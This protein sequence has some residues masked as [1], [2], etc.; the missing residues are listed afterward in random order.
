MI[1]ARIDYLTVS[2]ADSCVVQYLI[3]HVT[4]QVVSALAIL[5]FSY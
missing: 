4:Q 2:I 1:V 3:E 5:Q